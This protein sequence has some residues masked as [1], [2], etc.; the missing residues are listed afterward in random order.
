[1]LLSTTCQKQ[2]VIITG[3]VLMIV[4]LL[5]CFT[6]YNWPRTR[7]ERTCSTN[8]DSPLRAKE[9]LNEEE[10]MCKGCLAAPELGSRSTSVRESMLSLEICKEASCLSPG[11]WLHCIIGDA[12]N[13]FPRL[14][15]AAAVH[16]IYN[17]L[18]CH[19][20][21]RFIFYCHKFTVLI[22][23]LIPSTTA[24]LLMCGKALPRINMIAFMPSTT[25]F[26]SALINLTYTYFG[27]TFSLIGQESTKEY[28]GARIVP[29][30]NKEKKRGQSSVR[31]VISWR[32]HIIKTLALLQEHSF[33][34]CVHLKLFLKMYVFLYQNIDWGTISFL[35]VLK[36]WLLS[37][38]VDLKTVSF[39]CTD[40]CIPLWRWELLDSIRA[41]RGLS[42]PPMICSKHCRRTCQK[43]QPAGLKWSSF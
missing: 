28:L 11:S 31:S 43:P 16:Y 17:F 40:G 22:L 30:Y 32:R 13:C 7:R 39:N 24:E 27:L 9:N 34:L 15:S 42:L 6:F 25:I 8:N 41:S 35:S 38:W 1:M 33:C 10:W 37:F 23:I 5:F 19:W 18:L 12:N 3:A 2:K 21:Y 14:Q 29:Y 36:Y 4:L 20:M 26:L